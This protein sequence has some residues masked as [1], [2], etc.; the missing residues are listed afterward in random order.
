MSLDTKEVVEKTAKTIEELKGKIDGYHADAV[1]K[2]SVDKII[3]DIETTQENVQKVEKENQALK[4]QLQLL[5][6]GKISNDINELEVKSSK[7]IA[8]FLRQGDNISLE[9]KSMLSSDGASGGYLI[10][11]L[12]SS[13]IIKR[14]FETSNIRPLAS[15]EST[16][17]NQIEYLIDTDEVDVNWGM[18]TAPISDTDSAD[19]A[20]KVIAVHNLTAK[21][22]A[23]Q[24]LIDDS[25]IDIE[26][27]LINKVTQKM[28]RFENSAFI[29]GNGKGKPRGILT[30]PNY[31]VA[32][33]HEQDAIE[34]INL[35]HATEIT[36][37]G[38][39]ELQNS[40]IENYNNNA[41]WAMKR[42]T[43]GEVLKLVNTDNKFMAITP[44]VSNGQLLLLG[45][46]VVFMDDLPT[47]SANA[48]PII[49]GDFAS[50]YQILDRTGI[51]VIRDV[52]TAAPEVKFV[53]TK[54]VGGDVLN[55]EA[56]KIGKIST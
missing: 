24:D 14:I 26:A 48:L 15:V 17:S 46:R 38:L 18:E 19:V 44:D 33:V 20:K 35:G 55:F 6:S 2:D 16:G 5:G 36:S 7:A 29:N 50:A 27:W 1:T 41:V 21:P 43:F 37:N 49:Y 42:S 54:R 22:K 10:P 8:D 51:R 23:T 30:Y 3:A 31:A 53:T 32:G 45:K 4:A 11:K 25:E 9:Q 12:M 34:Q 52:V 47:I 56:I 13:K 28:S 40:L 39:I